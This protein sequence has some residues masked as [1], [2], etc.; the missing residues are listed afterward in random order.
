MFGRSKSIKKENSLENED[1]GFQ[2]KDFALEDKTK[3]EE[4]EQ[5]KEISTTP[6]KDLPRE[7]RTQKDLS[8]DN[9]IG[10]ISKGVSTRSRF[11]ILYNSMA[12]VS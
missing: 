3:V 1:A 2:H 4:L 12:F 7:W 5:C 11:R 6:P 8:L 9:I 10:E